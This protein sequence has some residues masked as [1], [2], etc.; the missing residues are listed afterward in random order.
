MTNPFG[1]LVLLGASSSSKSTSSGSSYF[2]II[3][4]VMVAAVWL[5]FLRP[6][7][8]RAKKQREA[9]QQIAP[10]DTIV[11]I[12][13]L[14]GKVVSVTDDRVVIDAERSGGPPHHLEFLRRGVQ[15][16]LEAAPVPED[17]HPEFELAPA[18][19]GSAQAT[20]SSEL[21]GTEDLEQDTEGTGGDEVTGASPALAEGTGDPAPDGKGRG[22]QASSSR[23]RR[24]GAGGSR[25]PT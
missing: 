10:G 11:T 1:A 4:I 3:L 12:G 9:N 22:G 19:E 6:Q 8:Q 5:L 7:Q 18:G 23:R 17:Q 2:F 20:S 14:V 15:G 25:R 16:K 21:T 24:S 13:G